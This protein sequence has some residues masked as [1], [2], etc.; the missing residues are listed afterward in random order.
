MNLIDKGSTKTAEMYNMKTSTKQN[1]SNNERAH[2]MQISCQ[3]QGNIS[4]TKNKLLRH[5]DHKLRNITRYKYQKQ[6]EFRVP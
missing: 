1:F 6:A 2:Q 4:G 3:W 5:R